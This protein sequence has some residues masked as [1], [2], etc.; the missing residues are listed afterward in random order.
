MVAPENSF[1][2]WV[3][4]TQKESKPNYSLVKIGESQIQ[5]FVVIVDKTDS[6]FKSFAQLIAEGIAV[7]SSD[8]SLL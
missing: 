8:C 7:S 5:G 2:L 3:D 1:D 4:D 6:N